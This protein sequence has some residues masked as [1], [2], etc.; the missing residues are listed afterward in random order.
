MLFRRAAFLDL[1]HKYRARIS[2]AITILRHLQ[3]ELRQI[4]ESHEKQLQP[5]LLFRHSIPFCVTEDAYFEPTETTNISLAGLL[6]GH[7]LALTHLD[8]HLDGS[9]PNEDHA[10]TARKMDLVSAT[11]YAI[12]MIYAAGRLLSQTSN[13][14]AMFRDAFEPISGFVLL[15]MY[16][17]WKERYCETFLD[18]PEKRLQD[19]IESSTSRL[20]GSG[21][22]ELMPQGCFITHGASAPPELIKT[23][24]M[25][26][27]LRQVVD[28]IADFEDD[29]RSGLVTVPL[30]HALQ[31][32]AGSTTVRDSVVRL[33]HGRTD[34][35]DASGD[36]L[37]TE[38][39]KLVEDSGAFEAS[40][41]LAHS[42]W[43]KASAYCERTL[44]VRSTGYLLLLD[45]KRAKLEML[46]K[47]GWHNEATE[48]SFDV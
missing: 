20:L 13:A 46:A 12:R 3:F 30:M 32:T 45:L 11:T 8:Y 36:E 48:A 9:V 21:Y 7:T 34:H 14:D 47:N 6:A 15:R 19:Y 39:R 17:D 44:G 2:E 5:E 27:K 22:W 35:S 33:W 43:C 1:S 41:Q 38:V 25:L 18:E 16:E 26:R 23:L 29:V 40:H 31:S 4:G 24:R 37:F 10:A 28:E 42:L